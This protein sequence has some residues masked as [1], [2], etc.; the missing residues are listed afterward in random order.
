M[1][2]NHQISRF[3]DYQLLPI[4]SC[5]KTVLFLKSSAS[6]HVSLL[7]IILPHFNFCSPDIWL[8]AFSFLPHDSSEAAWPKT[9][10]YICSSLYPSFSN[11]DDLKDIPGVSYLVKSS[12]N[13]FS[14]TIFTDQFQAHSLFQSLNTYTA[15]EFL[16]SPHNSG[17]QSR[18]ALSVSCS[19]L[20]E[21]LHQ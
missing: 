16:S 20:S 9:S 8:Q 11:V 18:L 4:C 3:T 2:K 12:G 6:L 10:F 15:A 17:P 1:K 13:S 19:F 21:F 5:F 7:W 14:S